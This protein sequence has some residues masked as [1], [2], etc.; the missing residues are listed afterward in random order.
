MSPQD[1]ITITY[2][3][4]TGDVQILGG[5]LVTTTV[6]DNA[7]LPIQTQ[8]PVKLE[9]IL[10]YHPGCVWYRGKIYC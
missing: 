5:N 7:N 8:Y 6:D 10:I 3:K 9:A 4:A 2:N 1:E